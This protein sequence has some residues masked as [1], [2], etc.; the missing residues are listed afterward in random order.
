[1]KTSNTF[2]LVLLNIINKKRYLPVVNKC[3]QN[4]LKEEEIDEVLEETFLIKLN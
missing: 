1:M 3:S 2:L 4:E